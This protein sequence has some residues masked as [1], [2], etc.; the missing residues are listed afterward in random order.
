MEA[1]TSWYQPCR[2]RQDDE[3]VPGDALCILQPFHPGVLH[4]IYPYA[5]TLAKQK[6]LKQR[7]LQ[8]PLHGRYEGQLNL[9]TGSAVL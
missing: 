9:A 8:Q 2:A 3:V 7:I 5:P 1:D 4:I 6:A